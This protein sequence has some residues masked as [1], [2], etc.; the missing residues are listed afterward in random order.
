MLRRLKSGAAA[1]VVGQDGRAE[2]RQPQTA[3]GGC[4]AAGG[5]KDMIIDIAPDLVAQAPATP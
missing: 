1:A 2:R 5:Q 3:G 4:G